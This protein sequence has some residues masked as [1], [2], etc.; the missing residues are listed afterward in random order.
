MSYWAS[1]TMAESHLADLRS[2]ASQR[3]LAAQ[4]PQAEPRR[5]DAVRSRLRRWLGHTLV[6]AGLHLLASTGP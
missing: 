6:Q 4:L 5:A 2:Q 1:G 3:R